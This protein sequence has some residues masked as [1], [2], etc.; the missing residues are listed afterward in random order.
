M[1]PEILKMN[2]MI[3]GYENDGFFY[4]WLKG[5]ILGVEFFTRDN[6]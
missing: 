3:K 2:F 4:R 1:G 6:L 5:L